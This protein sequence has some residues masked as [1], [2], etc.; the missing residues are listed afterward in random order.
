MQRDCQITTGAEFIFILK[1]ALG[2]FTLSIGQPFA[3]RRQSPSFRVML[4]ASSICPT[5]VL[6]ISENPRLQLEKKKRKREGCFASNGSNIG[7]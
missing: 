3:E 7:S 4:D 6:I 5:S 2:C 1:V